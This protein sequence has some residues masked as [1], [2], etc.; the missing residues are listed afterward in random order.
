[1]SAAIEM[2]FS[3]DKNRTDPTYKEGWLRIGLTIMALHRNGPWKLV[4]GA[5]HLRTSIYY[6]QRI[7]LN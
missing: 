6:I 3:M 1:M 7:M 5:R 4:I 2:S